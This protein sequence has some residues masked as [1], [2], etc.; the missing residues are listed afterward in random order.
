MQ[1]PKITAQI[2]I[3]FCV[4]FLGGSIAHAQSVREIRDQINDTA[5]QI[6]QIERE[7]QEY[8]EELDEI[9]Q[10]KQTLTGQIRELD[11]N[12]RKLQADISL[13]QNRISNTNYSIEELEIEIEDKERRIN[14]NTEAI[15]SSIR[16]IHKQ[17]QQS[18]IEALF[19]YPRLTD[20]W[21]N[22]DTLET[23]QVQLRENVDELR[24]LK[25][26]LNK[27]KQEEIAYRN[28]LSVLRRNLEGQKSVVD[29]NKNEKNKIL[30]ITENE[31]SKYQDYLDQAIERRQEFEQALAQLE[32]ELRVAIDPS[33]IPSAG[34]GILAWP[35][36][37]VYI[38]QR[39]GNTAFAQSGAYNGSG[40]NGIDFR[41]AIGTPILS[42]GNGVVRDYGNTDSIPGCY[43]YGKWI[44]VEHSTGLS[45][46]Y[47]HLSAI[48][49][50][51]GQ[52]ISTG[53]IIGYSGNTGYSTGP[54]L[55]FSVY[56]TQG[57]RVVR[58][59]D[60]KSRTNCANAHIPVAPFEAYLNPLDYL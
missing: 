14:N 26:S 5:A 50:S 4:A 36:K 3:V 53:D 15:R 56:A 47:A 44:L 28:N 7:I 24:L 13:T 54:H 2:I 25:E 32:S 33:S 11:I 17:D 55:H 19:T 34:S 20:F 38:T 52:V 31:E 57:V 21:A 41:A 22:V 49:T 9:A 18:L 30:D 48:T 29:Y 1:L 45:T 27:D 39:F 16:S 51:R 6:Q 40:H 35:L 42:A 12:A 10:E 8:E 37:S 23:F 58:L 46:M 59:G 43:S 60:I